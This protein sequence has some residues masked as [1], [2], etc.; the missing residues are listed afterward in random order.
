MHVQ[1]TALVLSHADEL[2]L[3]WASKI[4]ENSIRNYDALILPITQDVLKI[5]ITHGM[6]SKGV[7]QAI[8]KILETYSKQV[9]QIRAWLRIIRPLIELVL[10]LAHTRPEVL[11]IPSITVESLVASQ[12]YTVDMLRTLISSKRRR[13]EILKELSENVK[14][15]FD[16]G[17]TEFENLLM[18]AL[19]RQCSH[20]VILCTSCFTCLIVRKLVENN[21]GLRAKVNLVSLCTSQIPPTYLLHVALL[22]GNEHSEVM[23]ELLN[24]VKN[25]ILEYV[26]LSSTTY[27]AFS[28]FLRDFSSTYRE[29]CE[30]LLKIYCPLRKVHAS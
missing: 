1:I 6:T 12:H 4:I 16:T 23:D 29:F 17:M 15:S 13:A 28:K 21:P 11:V 14:R 3:S 19:A 26:V 8:S 22:M 25:Y 9:I 20:I 7:E 5:S 10:K 2:T 30:K 27:E 18:Y 24:F